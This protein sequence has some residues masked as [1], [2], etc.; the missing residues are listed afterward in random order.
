MK[1]IITVVA[2]AASLLSAP[3]FAKTSNT[4]SYD[5][6]YP[7]T[8]QSNAHSGGNFQNQWNDGNW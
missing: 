2:L 4:D 5:H 8:E 6:G 1:K 3:A 7:A